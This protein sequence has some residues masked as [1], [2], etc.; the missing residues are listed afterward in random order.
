MQTRR[1]KLLNRFSMTET[2]EDEEVLMGI[3]SA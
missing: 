2:A 1:K 3:R